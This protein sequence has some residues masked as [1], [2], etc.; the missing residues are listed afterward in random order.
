MALLQSSRL[1]G[2]MWS[3]RGEGRAVSDFKGRHF[4]GEIVLWAVRWY[5][6]YVWRRAKE[7]WRTRDS[8]PF[9]THII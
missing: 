4:E 8:G 3:E 2:E 9:P 5:C 7:M 6:R 1:S